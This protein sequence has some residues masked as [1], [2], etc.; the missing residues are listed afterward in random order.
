MKKEFLQ[1]IVSVQS[2]LKAPKTQENK[3]GGYK[4]RSC[5]DILEA[6][7]PLLA[8]AG[9]ALFLT[10]EVRQAGD[11]FYVVATATLTDGEDEASCRAWAREESQKK[12]CD[13]S[14]V[15]GSASSYAR[16]YA[17][18]GLLC[19]DD[20]RDADAGPDERELYLLSALQE[21]GG[22][23]SLDEL[24]FIYKKYGGEY[25]GEPRFMSAL[26]ARR[27]EVEDVRS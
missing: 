10:D 13:A 23:K 20:S 26:T 11:R 8:G 5:E 2:S 25:S 16:K 15:T 12:G 18:N 6:A 17:L 21:I 1:K 9:L 14:Q 27:K 4:Y 7:K 24:R 19:T 22:A 3:F